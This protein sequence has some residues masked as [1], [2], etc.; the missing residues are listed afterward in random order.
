MELIIVH[1]EN[2]KLIRVMVY[3]TLK[4]FNNIVT[5]HDAF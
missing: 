3:E 5:Y 2:F 4:M 1:L